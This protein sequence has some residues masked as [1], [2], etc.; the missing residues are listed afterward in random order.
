MKFFL[1]IVAIAIILGCGTQRA[2]P[3][4][5]NGI[6][7]I[8][9]DNTVL[10]VDPGVGGRITA[11]K[12][13]G[14]NFL[15]GRDVHPDYW[16]S[17]LWP[18]PQKEWGGSPPAELDNRPYTV[19]VKNNAINMVSRKDAKFGFV[20]F[21]QISGDRRNKYFSIK[22]T[23]TNKSDQVRNVAPWEVTRV[24]TK[25]LAFYPKGTGERRGNLADFATDVNGISW[26]KYEEDKLPA[27]HNKFF[28]D[29]S[30]GWVAQ[31]NGDLLF[32]KKF[33]EIDADKA[34]PAES[35]IEVYTNPGKSYVEIEQQGAYQ[36]LQPGESLTWEVKWFLRKIPVTID[37]VPGSPELV[38]YVRKILES[39]RSAMK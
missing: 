5:H 35:E 28:D 10:E 1:T 4:N 18:S 34:A 31:V 12:L 20:F 25:G 3:A 16:G 19:E 36:K 11:L 13:E 37:P 15:T 32:I 17:T 29:G 33:P 38:S 6:F 30:E 22:Y 9:I 7:S 21:K 23:I 26:F 39:H 14:K 24:H 2:V 27:T 8:E